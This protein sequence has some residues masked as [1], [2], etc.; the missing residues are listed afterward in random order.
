[1]LTAY[2]QG[3]VGASAWEQLCAASLLPGVTEIHC[4]VWGP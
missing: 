3:E 2:N 4:T 1:M